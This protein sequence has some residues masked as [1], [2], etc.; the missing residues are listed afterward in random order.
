VAVQIDEVDIGIF[1]VGDVGPTD[2]VGV[3]GD[4]LGCSFHGYNPRFINGR[5]GFMLFKALKS[6]KPFLASR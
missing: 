1:R 3:T 6:K 5:K 2:T 4:S